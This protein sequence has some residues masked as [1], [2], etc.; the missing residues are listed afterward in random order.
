MKSYVISKFGSAD[1]I[2]L[3]ETEIPKPQRGE[4]LVKVYANSL[5]YRDLII[6]SGNYP[7]PVP[8]NRIPV[9]DA[10]GEIVTLGEGVTRFK[11]G[12]RVITTFFPNWFG[13]SFHAKVDMW[14]SG[15]DGWL[16][17][18]KVVSAE[19]LVQMPNHL[20]YE[21]AAT[22]PC[23]AL[24]AWSALKGVQAGDTVLTQGSGGV[25][26]FAIQLAKAIGAKIISTTG[27][28]DKIDL[29]KSLG[30]HEVINYKT[31]LTWG[32]TVNKLTGGTGVDC[33]VEVAGP[34]SIG[35]SLKAVRKGGKISLIGILGGAEG[36]IPYMDLFLSF[37][38]MEVITTG[39]RQGLEELLK[40][41][42]THKIKPVIDRVFS[43][44]NA[45]EAFSYYGSNNVTGKIVI[46]NY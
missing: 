13:G 26:L 9:S 20:S 33:V 38:R 22:L 41:V 36:G 31:D 35:Q 18:Y 16:T 27:S 19:S 37:T 39:N 14:V 34:T 23:A 1:G 24:T 40:V 25:T 46:K 42:N 29:L 17:E 8:L 30:S 11:T 28:D 4:V 21:E 32:E 10:A 45:K 5:N 44:E 7:F 2:T 15:M 43:F 12:D 6:M 3:K